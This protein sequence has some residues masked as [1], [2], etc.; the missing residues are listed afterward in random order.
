M[1]LSGSQTYPSINKQAVPVQ[2][3]ELDGRHRSLQQT[4]I[5][6]QEVQATVHMLPPNAD[7]P[8]DALVAKINDN[9]S[10]ELG[11][12]GIALAGLTSVSKQGLSGNALCEIGEMTTALPL[13]PSSGAA[14]LDFTWATWNGLA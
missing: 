4:S 5:S 11:P 9:M 3:A 6:T 14:R 8:Y 7:T 10:S 13:S 1:N 12:G 2:G